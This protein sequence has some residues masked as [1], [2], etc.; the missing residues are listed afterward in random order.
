MEK[1]KGGTILYSYISSHWPHVYVTHQIL[2][3]L[4]HLSMTNSIL[5][6]HVQFGDLVI[7]L[8]KSKNS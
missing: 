2:G 7:K 5:L 4:A 6:Y 3:K 8:N 1:D